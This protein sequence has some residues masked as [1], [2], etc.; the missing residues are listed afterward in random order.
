MLVS[1]QITDEWGKSGHRGVAAG[2]KPRYLLPD[3]ELP[4]HPK[5]GE[6]VCFIGKS[7]RAVYF[8]ANAVIHY[9]LGEMPPGMIA[10]TNDWRLTVQVM[11]EYVGPR[12][13]EKEAIYDICRHDNDNAVGVWQRLPSSKEDVDS[14]I[15]P[16]ITEAR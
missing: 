16:P 3:I 4:D 5:I 9:P 11:I 12:S 10:R 13:K 15:N 2:E 8:R 6:H 1:F 7:D 14:K